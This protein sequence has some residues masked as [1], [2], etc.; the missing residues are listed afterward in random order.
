[1]R[2]HGNHFTLV[3]SMLLLSVGCLFVGC[4]SSTDPT[5]A[6]NVDQESGP[7]PLT[8]HFTDQSVAGNSPITNWHWDFGDQQ[9]SNEQNPTHEYQAAGTYEV[10]LTITTNQGTDTSA[11]QSIV[12]TSGNDNTD[13][14]IEGNWGGYWWYQGTEGNVYITWEY[15]NGQFTT[16]IPSASVVCKGTYTVDD[17]VTP[18]TIDITITESNTPGFVVG[19]TYRGYYEFH[20]TTLYRSQMFATRPTWSSS[21]LD[22]DTGIVF[23]ADP[24]LQ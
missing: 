7:A 11:S 17:T 15:Q 20:G 2:T 6:F 10:T 19:N 8:V 4:P 5:A 13:Q 1:M 18:K 22:P 23:V 9:T 14:S 24:I 3:A 12:V 16:T 21:V